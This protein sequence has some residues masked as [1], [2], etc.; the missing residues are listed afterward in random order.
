M[1]DTIKQTDIKIEQK[2]DKIE[3]L[4]KKSGLLECKDIE[5]GIN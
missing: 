5:K 3:L 2:G 1:G 4:E